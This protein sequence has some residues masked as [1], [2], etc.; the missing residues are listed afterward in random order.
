M[1]E[2]VLQRQ[3]LPYP[4]GGGVLGAVRLSGLKSEGRR[5]RAERRLKSEIRECLDDQRPSVEHARAGQ[6]PASA[7]G[8]ASRLDL[9]GRRRGHYLPGCLCRLLAR[10]ARAIPVGRS[11]R[12]ASESLGDRGTG[13]GVALVPDGL[14]ADQCGVL[15]GVAGVGQSPDGV[16]RRECVASCNQ[17]GVAV[18]RVGAAQGSG[19]LV[20]GNDLRRASDVRGFGGVDIG[21][22]ERTV[23]AVL[24]AEHLMVCAVFSRPSAF[25]LGS[26]DFQVVLAFAGGLPTGAAE[27]DLDGDAAG[28]VAGVRLVAARADAL[29]TDDPILCA[30]SGVRADEYRVPGTLRDVEES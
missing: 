15:A 8:G 18:E 4:G 20:G 30:G 19:G 23:A 22:E 24:S 14:P 29:A 6:T 1:P 9:G 11:A 13:A 25:G 27:Q 28:G 21:A 5:P 26:S 2:Q 7:S 12:G 10:L 16:P 17:R 3:G